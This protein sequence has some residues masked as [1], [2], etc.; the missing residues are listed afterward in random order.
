M[1]P[2][3]R[4]ECLKMIRVKNDVNGNSRHVVHWLGLEPATP[5][6]LDISARYDR[7]LRAARTVGGRKFHNRQYGGGVVFQAYACEMPER[8]A[9]IRALLA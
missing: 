6:G 3:P 4:D 7:V 9:L 1:N 8:V 2:A 5:E